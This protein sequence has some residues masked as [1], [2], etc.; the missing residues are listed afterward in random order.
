MYGATHNLQNH[1]EYFLGGWEGDMLVLKKNADLMELIICA[2]RHADFKFSSDDFPT[3]VDNL[4]KIEKLIQRQ[5]NSQS[6]S[7]INSICGT[8]MICLSHSLFKKFD[9][10]GEEIVDNIDN[11]ASDSGDSSSTD[12]SERL[13]SQFHMT[14]WPVR[15]CCK[16]KL[17][18]LAA[19][20]THIIQPLCAYDIDS[21]I[22]SPTDYENKLH[23][24]TVLVA[25]ALFHCYIKKNKCH[26]FTLQVR[27]ISILRHSQSKGPSSPY[28]RRKL[29]RSI[30]TNHKG[31][32][33][34]H[35]NR[36]WEAST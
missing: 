26:V 10:N 11:S 21:S 16:L 22:L 14:N 5:P 28:K 20:N 7:V 17:A 27:K 4:R 23:G 2:S 24:A 3:I 8:E 30:M 13:P 1:A 32:G 36:T 34:Y 9:N 25:M 33:V 18:E 31:K 15:E 19:T 12:S 35:S 6:L 29:S